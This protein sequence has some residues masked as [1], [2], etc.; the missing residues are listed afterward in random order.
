MLLCFYERN[1]Y[2]TPGPWSLFPPLRRYDH[3]PYSTPVPAFVF[4]TW[5]ERMTTHGRLPG[6]AARPHQRQRLLPLDLGLVLA[7]RAI[8]GSETASQRRQRQTTGTAK[9]CTAGPAISPQLG[10][11][12]G[13]S[14]VFNLPS[15]RIERRL[16][17]FT[18]GPD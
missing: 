10:R 2:S 18:V 3:N 17:W 1:L 9:R 5:A 4:N 14:T 16:R 15:R 13:D 12:F 7:H 6:A 8:A 11:D